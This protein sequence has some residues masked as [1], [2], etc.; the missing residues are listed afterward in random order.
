VG[1]KVPFVFTGIAGN[2][3]VD[4]VIITLKQ[5]YDAFLLYHPANL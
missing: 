1:I 3:K 5:K 2:T 4:P